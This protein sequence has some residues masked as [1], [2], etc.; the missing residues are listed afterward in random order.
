[1]EPELTM[2]PTGPISPNTEDCLWT[3]QSEV[4][5]QLPGRALTSAPREE[6]NLVNYLSYL[7]GKGRISSAE[8]EDGEI[9]PDGKV[10]QVWHQ[11][12]WWAIAKACGVRSP[13]MV[14]M[15]KPENP[16]DSRKQTEILESLSEMMGLQPLGMIT[17]GITF[18]FCLGAEDPGSAVPFM[19]RDITLPATEQEESLTGIRFNPES[20]AGKHNKR[21]K[22]LLA[23]AERTSLA[24]QS[25]D[26]S[27]EIPVGGQTLKVLVVTTPND[28]GDGQGCCTMRAAKLLLTST[29]GQDNSPRRIRQLMQRLTALQVKGIG[30]TDLKA[31]LIPLEEMPEKW[32]E[33]DVVLDSQCIKRDVTTGKLTAITVNAFQSKPSL[34]ATL[35]NGLLQIHPLL[36]LA[37][38]DELMSVTRNISR[39]AEGRDLEAL[40][41]EAERHLA[42]PP[43]KGIE[44]GDLS[45]LARLLVEEL[46]PAP[47]LREKRNAGEEDPW[48]RF[49]ARELDDNNTVMGLLANGYHPSANPVA[50]K[51]ATGRTAA[52]L[53]SALTPR[54]PRKAGLPYAVV[55]G[56][57]LLGMHWEFAGAV[58]PRPGYLRP[59]WDR[60]RQEQMAG[61]CIHPSDYPRFKPRLDGA[62]LDGDTFTI[63]LFKDRKG[64]YHGLIL[65]SPMSPGGGHLGRIT[66]KDGQKMEANGY[67][68]YRM[69][70]TELSYNW[71]HDLDS[72]GKGK[73]PP[74]IKASPL[75]EG[76]QPKWST[77]PGEM[78]EALRK[79]TMYNYNIGTVTN[80]TF[81]LLASG[82]W[83][84]EDHWSNIS[85]IIDHCHNGTANTDTAKEDF[86]NSLL[87]LTQ[88]SKPMEKRFF[89]GKAE[90]MLTRHLREQQEKLNGTRSEASLEAQK[91]LRPEFEALV[92]NSKELVR[93][94]RRALEI[95]QLMANGPVESLLEE[96]E[97]EAERKAAEAYAGKIEAWRLW[98][99]IETCIDDLA[100]EKALSPQE[101][102][103][104][105]AE[106]KAEAIR[107]SREA[108]RAAYQQYAESETAVGGQMAKAL[109]RM[110]LL[111]QKR[112]QKKDGKVFYA[113]MSQASAL[114]DEE[115]YAAHL[116]TAAYTILTRL[117]GTVKD[118]ELE[119][120][121]D[122]V[123]GWSSRGRPSLFRGTNP[124]LADYLG[125]EAESYLWPEDRGKHYQAIY[126]GIMPETAGAKHLRQIED[127]VHVFEVTRI[128]ATPEA[129]EITVASNWA[130]LVAQGEIDQQGNLLAA[131]EAGV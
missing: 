93:I 13:A 24:W 9:M 85:D 25:H 119:I 33:Y 105:R 36:D 96:L 37:D 22:A 32:Q 57:L 86:L 1:M 129:P 124:K 101:A 97:P 54:S 104:L 117:S 88:A 78:H 110:H 125:P 103:M 76:E 108:A 84:P 17:S 53:E 131:K 23:R 31:V 21:V 49:H 51:I 20:P 40:S 120:G 60:N 62:D 14:T 94:A 4:S 80:A 16:E 35:I 128:P 26:L 28:A 81:V 68:A 34:K 107:K 106:N 38:A 90:R 3:F 75:P 82:L 47:E 18:T 27:K 73:H 87:K 118:V 74:K 83:D 42:N 44:Y 109:R 98:S 116:G 79:L 92:A 7:L 67:H 15:R 6:L 11:S 64:D 41:A 113:S 69:A 59:V 45:D 10:R 29:R 2:V 123:I 48:S 55:S 102:K 46:C 19:P 63:V 91:W 5:P 39:R 70:G 114:P 66:R 12:N 95:R 61:I 121:E 127:T 72:E 99:Q 52:W 30:E 58:R 130:K 65:R 100:K 50:A 71:L 8:V 89:E 77:T 122:C 111:D 112:W 56:E 126:R 115:Q 43:R